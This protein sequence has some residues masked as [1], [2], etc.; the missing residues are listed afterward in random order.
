MLCV[1]VNTFSVMLR[2]KIIFV[3]LKR[4][5]LN[6][7]DILASN[8]HVTVHVETHFLH[9][10]EVQGYKNISFDK[11]LQIYNKRFF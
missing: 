4:S 5:S 9:K 3:Q 2:Q 7:V 10:S 8:L 11:A 1:P 6:G